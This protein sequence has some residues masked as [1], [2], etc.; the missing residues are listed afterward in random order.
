[1]NCK[2]C[3]PFVIFPDFQIHPRASVKSEFQRC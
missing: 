1:M 2:F 3:S